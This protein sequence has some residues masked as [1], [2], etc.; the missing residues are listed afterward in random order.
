MTGLADGY[1]PVPPGKLAAVVTSLQ[2]LSPA[3]LRPDVQGGWSL[4]RQDAP[5]A[6]HYRA[7]FGRLGRDWLWFSRLYMSE[8]EL[9][10]VIADP[11]V[12]IYTLQ[13]GGRDE[14]LLEL[15]FRRDGECELAFFA[16][17][18]ELQGQ[19]AGRWLMNRG[20]ELAWK[21]PIQRFWVHTCTFDH[22]GALGF[23]QRSGFAPFKREV[24][25]SDDPRI[26]GKLDRDAA[27]QAPIL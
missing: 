22:P 11:K 13:A 3:P 16:L 21:E 8:A 10:A 15:D 17:S 27:P 1:H 19:G 18:A 26:L 20:I 25:I 6:A 5:D 24:E 9:L 2:M 14:G 23:Y 4:Q 12:H 7:L